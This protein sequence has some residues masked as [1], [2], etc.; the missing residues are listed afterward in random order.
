MISVRKKA[1]LN[2]VPTVFDVTN[3]SFYSLDILKCLN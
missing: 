3:F 2:Y 1:L